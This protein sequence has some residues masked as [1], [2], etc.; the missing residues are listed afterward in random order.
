MKHARPTVLYVAAVRDAAGIN[1]SP[2][3]VLV[4]GDR[5]VAAG[6]PDRLPAELVA[7]AEVIERPND[8]LLP[9]MVNAH[10]HLELTSIGP[11][12]YDPAGGFVGWIK[13]VQSLSPDLDVDW[14]RP[15]YQGALQCVEAGVQAVGDIG[16]PDDVD[17]IKRAVGL[18]GVTY[19]QLFGIGPPFDDPAK[20]IVNDTKKW[21][22]D[23][24]QPHAPYSVGP[25][26]Y[27]L[28]QQSGRPVSTHLAEHLEEAEFIADCKGPLLDY[29]KQIGKWDAAFAAHYGQG[30]SPVQWMRPHL[31]TA[32]G[33]GG[34]LVAHCNYVSDEDI[35][36]LADTNTSVAYC[37]IASEYFGHANHRCL[38]MLAAGV[39]VCLG[40][41]SIVG[42]VA[43]D[44]QPLGLLG[45]MRR[46]YERD[47]IDPDMLLAMATTH[48]VRALRLD[49][50]L[51]TLQPGAPARF[52]CLP[53]NPESSTD[54]LVQVLTRQDQVE[55]ISFDVPD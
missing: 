26:I 17:S 44:P 54:P 51:A 39:N 48:G 10:T 16:P 8:L 29:L 25:G 15:V 4:Q 30:L 45:A 2:G 34:W 24:L 20:W 50:K 55:A 49:S 6:E 5:V 13:M 52:A 35:A 9:A 43:D 14:E 47:Q 21:G 33:Q 22:H 31:E 32:A 41:D 3:A 1:A 23:G 46:L 38:D 11:Q 28:A 53:I 40:T 7:Q 19:R 42:T 18:D 12:P 27:Q 37:P 36:I